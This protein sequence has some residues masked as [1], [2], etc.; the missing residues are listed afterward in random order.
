M[1]GATL[2]VPTR[3]AVLAEPAGGRLDNLVAEYVFGWR[4]FPYLLAD[5]V[6]DGRNAMCPPDLPVHV[7]NIYPVKHYS[8][9]TGV[10]MTVVDKLREWYTNVDLHAA[11]NWTVAVW[12]VNESDDGPVETDYVLAAGDTLPLAV[13]RCAVLCGLARRKWEGG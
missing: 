5:A 11:G 1:P 8:V 2:F 12:S 9:G 6:A 3:D 4:P 7:S 10:A 13:A